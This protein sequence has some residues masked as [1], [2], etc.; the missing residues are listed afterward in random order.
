MM[1]HQ[2]DA[3]GSDAPGLGNVGGGGFLG[4]SQDASQRTPGGNKVS[5]V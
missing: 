5:Q 4:A 2:Y 1:N 3:Y